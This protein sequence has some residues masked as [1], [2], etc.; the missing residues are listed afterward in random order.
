MSVRS[1]KAKRIGLV[2]LGYIIAWLAAS[3]AVWWKNRGIS[4]A[5]Q[6][7]SSGMFAFGDSVLF[8][9]IVSLVSIA[10]TL[11][12]L[13]LIDSASRFWRFTSYASLVLATTA[14]LEVLWLFPAGNARGV[15]G[16]LM[17]LGF[18]RLFTAPLFL[19]MYIPGAPLA[20]GSDRRRFVISCAIELG[21]A[22]FVGSIFMLRIVLNFH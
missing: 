16:T 20:R 3:A 14:L 12:L 10:P 6:L 8:L 2:V 15:M 5:D 4:A 7:A 21:V 17:L 9:G 19:L 1:S 13:S 18:I 11:Y 22:A